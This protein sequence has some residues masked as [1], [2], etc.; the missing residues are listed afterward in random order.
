MEEKL[1]F[2][3]GSNINL[4]QMA[5]RCPAAQVVGPVVLEDHEL[6]FRGNAGGNGV[7][8]IAPHKG[9]KVHGLLWKIT[10]DCERSLDRY[11]GYPHLY[12]K[13]PVNVWGMSG[14]ELTVMAYIMTGGEWWRDPALPSADY[15]GGIAEGYRQTGLPVSE[16]ERSVRN[17]RDEIR[18]MAAL[19][20]GLGGAK[21]RPPKKKGRDRHER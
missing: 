13:E 14:R 3:Y 4:N 6:L 21:A 15:Y 11:E 17:T 19:E 12:G 18:Q 10:P 8:T 7:A 16:L 20:S 5:V 2:A 1:Y 9:H